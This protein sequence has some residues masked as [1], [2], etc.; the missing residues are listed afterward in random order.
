MANRFV[1]ADIPVTN[2]DRAVKF[3]AALIGMPVPIDDSPGFRFAVFPHEGDAVGGCL[4]PAGDGN[5]PSDK[6]P[7]LYINV[8]GRM[9]QA[10]DAAGANGGRV[11]EQP[12]PIGPHGFRAVVIDSEGNR[13]ALH[14]MKM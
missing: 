3:Y 6:G 12:H 10:I 8:E 7:L 4:V 14:S 9:K 11:V 1:W 2:L 5:A 13:V